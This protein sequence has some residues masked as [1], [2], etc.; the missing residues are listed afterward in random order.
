M[1]VIKENEHG[2]LLNYFGLNNRFY[3]AITIMTYFDFKDPD[4]PLKEQEMWPFVQGELGKDAILD[5]AMPKPKGEVLVW[6]RCFTPDGKARGASR[7]VLQTG[8]VEKT[9]D[10]F[11]NRY[12]KKAAGIGYNISRPEPFTEIPLTYE[13]AFGGKTYEKNPVGRGV[14][15]VTTA[16]GRE[17]HPLP[18]IEDPKHRV[19]SPSDKPD[20]AGF[21]PIHYLWPQ[22]SKKLGTYDNKWFQEKW[23]FYPDDM[24]WTYFNAAPEDQQMDNYLTV[25]QYFSVAGMHPKS[26]ILESRLP[27]IRHRFFVNQLVDVLKPEGETIFKEVLPHIDTLCLFPHAEK[28]IAIWRGTAEIQ[29]DE[30]I[31]IPHLYIISESPGEAPGTIEKYYEQF[32]KRIDRAVPVDMAPQMEDAKKRFTALADMLKDLPLQIN[33]RIAQNLGDAPSVKRTPA[34]LAAK[35]L[36]LIDQQTKLL[37]DG[38]KRIAALKKDF[39]HLMK[40]DTGGFVYGINALNDAKKEIAKLPGLVDQMKKMKSDKIKA[41]QDAAKEAFAGINPALLKKYGIDLDELMEEEKEE[42]GNPWQESGM[43]F[44]D[45]CH[46][47]L[48][49]NP[50]LMSAFRALGFRPYTLKRNWIGFAKEETRFERALWG[51]KAG[52][53][54]DPNTFVIP[55][56]LVIPRFTGPTLDHISVRPLPADPRPITSQALLAAIMD[57]SSDSYV[58]GS[59]GE[60]LALSVTEGKAVVRVENEMEAIL[61]RQDIGDISAIVAMKDPS[62]KPGKE[63]AETIKKAPQFLV[64]TQSHANAV[65]NEADH[66]PWEKLCPLAESLFLIDGANVIESKRSGTDIWQWI[67]DALRPGLAPAEETKPKEIDVMEPGAVASLIPTIDT[68]AI[69][70]KVQKVLMDKMQPKMDMITAKEKLL[71][72]KF[73]SELG[74]RGID[75]DQIMKDRPSPR[76]AEGA[77]PF[78]EAKKKYVQNFEQLRQK[79]NKQVLKPAIQKELDEGNASALEAFATSEKQYEA[80]MKQLAEAKKKFEAGPSDWAKK[81]MVK[82]GLDPDDP[83]PLKPLTREEVIDRHTQGLSLAGKNLAGA[84]LSGLDLTEADLHRANIQ[85]TNFKGAILDRADLTKAIATEADFTKASMKGAIFVKG[86]FQKAKFPEADMAHGNMTSAMMSE[87]DLAGANLSG[88]TLTRTLFEKAIL[89]KVRAMNAKASQIYCLSADIT[90]ADFTGADLTK[91]VFLKSTIDNVNFSQSTLRQASILESKGRQIDFSGSDMHNSRI[92][93]GSELPDSNFTQTNAGQASWMKSN[94]S[95][96]DFRGLS[97]ERGL[98]EGCDLSGSNLSGIKAKQTRFTKS[99]L[100]DSNLKEINLFQGSLRKS[101]L[102]RTDLTKAN[103]YG[104]EFYR[105]GVGETKLDDANLKMTKLYKREDLLP[106]PSDKKKK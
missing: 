76:L 73:R 19:G 70:K 84:D 9:L 36:A 75:L 62:V 77:N 37:A 21:G 79:L 31:D 29:D 30:G 27:G 35:S 71:L 34:D 15:P 66:A 10:V 61:L 38:E 63:A 101:K 39:G 90:G 57:V 102:V 48:K 1:K 65:Q 12:W 87:A 25:N 41:F 28:G 16:T 24:N 91:G 74:K 40:I 8:T 17:Q 80:G 106:E 93:M 18:N 98:V 26:Q 6:G 94:L 100:S 104:A 82:A 86:I 89:K 105:T 81:L 99:N 64:V 14:S 78:T 51:L 55:A 53:G 54:E 4:N 59:K 46:E 50:E 47:N 49:N 68:A 69:H 88:A 85:K 3:L 7:V 72:D 32:K 44:L 11:G 95:G 56:G 33:D 23:P 20:P 92:L 45:D 67:F 52:K 42:T 43:R 96:S 97:I 83:T 60:A 5:M 13:R 22:R 58:E 2:I 103:L